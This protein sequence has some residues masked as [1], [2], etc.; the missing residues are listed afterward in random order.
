MG[1]AGELLVRGPQ[2]FAGYWNNDQDTGATVRDG[3]LR[4]GDIAVM[5]LDGFV[6]IVD[7]K[8]D[9]I[10]TNGL[11]VFPSEIEH[12]LLEHPAI[13]D[14]A[15]VGLTDPRPGQRIVGVVVGQ[16]GAARN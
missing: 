1:S 9:L 8:D 12:V 11:G 7:R 5:N 4:T 14:C 6:T 16:P 3:W 2:V 13:A 15:V 10:I